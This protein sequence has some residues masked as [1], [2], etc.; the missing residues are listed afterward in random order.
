MGLLALHQ[1]VQHLLG[2]VALSFLQPGGGGGLV[3]LFLLT[4]GGVIRLL[5]SSRRGV[6]CYTQ[7]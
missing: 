7:P 4:G 6:T 5:V 3:I 2:D 1:S